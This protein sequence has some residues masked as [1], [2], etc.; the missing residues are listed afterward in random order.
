MKLSTAGL[1]NIRIDNSTHDLCAVGFDFN[2]KI[3][4]KSF[5]LA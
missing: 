5:R 2:A 4:K 1:L 3:Q